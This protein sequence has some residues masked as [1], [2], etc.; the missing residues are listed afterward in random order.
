MTEWF[1]KDLSKLT[2]VSVQ[3]LHHYDRINLLKPSLRLANGYRIYSLKDLLK[4]QQI[5]ALK[6]FG[7]ELS[8]IKHL[9]DA[10]Q[11]VKD[12]FAMQAEFL[13]KKAER[14][15]E[16]SKILKKI[17][18]DCSDNESI[19]WQQVLSLIEVYNMTQSLENKW[20]KEV[21]NQEE[22]KQYAE[23]EQSIK[24]KMNADEIVKLEQDWD[25]LVQEV[26]QS[27]Q[28]DPVSKTSIQLAK[29]W[30][31]WVNNFYGKE[32]AHIRTKLFERGFGEGFGLEEHGLTPEIISW[33][34][35]AL[36]AYWRERIIFVLNQVGKT[37]SQD[38]QKQWNNL[39][40]EMYGNEHSR[41]PEIIDRA[42]K[43]LDISDEVKVW[44]NNLK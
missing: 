5:I 24:A 18:N 40:D 11:D 39:L 29:K 21:L 15:F 34:Q 17:T 38:V 2:G 37:S 8:Q 30:M 28:K 23:F 4:L 35:E 26:K 10:Q 44:L 16:A 1:V 33:I 3:T 7:F 14:L 27:L 6:F 9:L 36:D 42:L 22:L 31:D 32:F 25:D 41:K 12:N 43:E 13:Q 19:S 20:V